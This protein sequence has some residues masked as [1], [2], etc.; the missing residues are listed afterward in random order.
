MSELK[1]TIADNLIELRK[2]K[3]Y[4]QQDLGNML[5]YS[6]KAISKW[7]KGES[8]PDIEVLYQLANLYGVTL[9][10]LTKEG[11]YEEKKEYVIP[12]YETRNKVLI[13]LLGSTIVWFLAI[14]IFVYFIYDEEKIYF[15]PI[16]IWAI[17]LNC[18]VLLYFNHKWGR[19]G[20]KLPISTVLTWGLI[21][22]IYLSIIYVSKVNFWPIFLIGIP[23]QVALAL[24]SQIKK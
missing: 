4:T 1:K 15:W 22:S 13:T 19:R 7:E 2:R 14:I 12:K 17:P 20:F 24:M 5:G 6:D 9:D 3:K 18:L 8:L 21:I 16:F 10:F 11:S 23:I